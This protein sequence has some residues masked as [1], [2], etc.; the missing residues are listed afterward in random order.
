[1]GGGF[2][3]DCGRKNIGYVTLFEAV[4]WTMC[5]FFRAAVA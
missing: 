1:M 2:P 3:A 5:C 4:L